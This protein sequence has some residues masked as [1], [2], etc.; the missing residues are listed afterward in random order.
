MD[1]DMAEYY[2]GDFDP[3]TEDDSYAYLP[4]NFV[5]YE[6]PYRYEGPDPFGNSQKNPVVKKVRREVYGNRK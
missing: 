6:K 1:G 2:S 3:Y 5:K 4:K